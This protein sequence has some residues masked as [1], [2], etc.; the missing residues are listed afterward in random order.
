MR[1]PRAAVP[2]MRRGGAAWGLLLAPGPLLLLA[3][4]VFMLLALWP[5]GDS[6][7]A[8]AQT[9]PALASVATEDVDDV[10]ASVVAGLTNPDSDSATVYMRHRETGGVWPTA[11][12]ATTTGTE[13][14]FALTGLTSLTA[15]QV[16]VSLDAAFAAKQS[17][18]FTTRGPLRHRVFAIDYLTQDVWE[19]G[20][21]S[22]VDG[23]DRNIGRVPADVDLILSLTEHSDHFLYGMDV[24]GSTN[25]LWR[26]NDPDDPASWAEVCEMSSTVPD[27]QAML[28]GGGVLYGVTNNAVYSVNTT[29][30]SF[31][32]IGQLP[33]GLSVARGATMHNGAAYVADHHGEELYRIPDITSPGTQTLNY[34]LPSG[35]APRGLTSSQGQ[36]LLMAESSRTIYR[37]NNPETASPTLTSLGTLDTSA[38]HLNSLGAYATEGPSLS[39]DP[40]LAALVNTTHELAVQAGPS[41]QTATIREV[42]GSTGDLTLS[43]SEAGLSCATQTDSLTLTPPGSIWVMFCSAG[44]NT[45]RIE[46]GGNADTGT[47]YGMTI[48]LGGFGAVADVTGAAASSTSI[49]VM[50]TATAGATSYTVQWRDPS[51]TFSTTRQATATGASA[52]ISSLSAASSYYIRVKAVATGVDGAWSTPIIV[53]T[54][55]FLYVVESDGVDELRTLNPITGS[56][57]LVTAINGESNPHGLGSIAGVLYLIGSVTDQLLR[58][59]VTTGNTTAIGSSFTSSESNPHGLAACDDGLLY[60]VGWA[61][62]RLFSIDPANGTLT[63]IGTSTGFGVGETIPSG[64]ACIGNQLYMAGWSNGTLYELDKTDGTASAVDSSVIAFGVS[65]G[66][67]NGLANIGGV[68]YMNGHTTD[69]LYR[70]S[71]T[72]GIATL[73]SSIGTDSHYGLEMLTAAPGGVSNVAVSGTSMSGVSVT[74]NAGANA[75]S[76]KIRWRKDSESFNDTRSTTSTTTSTAITGLE[77]STVYYVDVATQRTGFS[78]ATAVEAFGSTLSGSVGQVQNVSASATGWDSLS[79]TWDAVVGATTYQVQ[80]RELPQAFSSARQQ[81]A[82]GTSTTISGLEGNTEYFIRVWAVGTTEGATSSP[83]TAT[84]DTR[85]PDQATNVSATSTTANSVTVTWNAASRAASYKV[86]WSTVSGVYSALSQVVTSATSATISSLLSG[87]TYYVQVIATNAG[88]DATPS[89]TSSATTLPGQA[90]G[91]ALSGET[92]ASINA[93]WSPVTGASSYKVQWSLTSGSFSASNQQTSL[94]PSSTISGLTSG[95]LY[96]VR[97]IAVGSAGDGTPSA[98]SSA[99]T[100]GTTAPPPGSHSFDITGFNQNSA[101]W[102]GA[103]L[104]DSAYIENGATA[105]LREVRHTGGSNI[106]I[107]LSSASDDNP[108]D[109]GPQFTDAVELY[110][111]SFEFEAGD[112][113]LLVPGPRYSGNAFTGTI[114]PYHWTVP[115]NVDWLTF[116][117]SIPVGA[118]VTLT[119]HDG[120]T[121]SP[122]NAPPAQVSNLTLSTGANSILASWDATTGATSYRVEWGTSSGSYLAANRQ[123]IVGATS[124]TISGL[125][126]STTYYVRVRASN[127]FGDGPYS[128]EAFVNTEYRVSGLILTD[129][130]SDRLTASWNSLIGVDGYR[131]QWTT[132]PGTYGGGLQTDTVSN[133]AVITGLTSGTVYYVRVIAR[134]AGANYG[135]YST[136]TSARTL[137]SP[138]G[139]VTNVAAT[140]QTYNTISLSWDAVSGATGYKIQWRTSSGQFSASAQIT[141]LTNSG[142]ITGLA[143]GTTYY[144]QVISTKTGAGDGTPSAAI[145]ATTALQSPAKVTGVTLSTTT[146]T[147]IVVSWD[148]TTHATGYTVQWDTTNSFATPVA[149]HAGQD[150]T[151][152]TYT[153]GGL[154]A[155][156]TYYVRVIATRVNAADALP[157][158]VKALTTLL[159]PPPQ[160]TGVTATA[161]NHFSI[162]VAW[163]AS[164]GADE[165]RVEWKSGSQS[166]TSGRSIES[167]SSPASITGLA[168][169]IEYSIRV[170]ALRIRGEDATPSAEVTATTFHRPPS[171][172]AAVSLATTKSTEITVRWSPSDTADD[173]RVQWRDDRGTFGDTDQIITS[174]TSLVIRN[175]T[176][177][178]SYYVRIIPIRT[179]ALPGTPSVPV[180]IR[181]LRTAPD[182]PTNLVLTVISP[183]SIYASWVGVSGATHYKLQWRTSGGAYGQA[184]YRDV[185]GNEFTITGL[186]ASTTYYVRVITHVAGAEDSAGVENSI[187]TSPAGTPDR[188]TGLRV[189][190]S[191]SNTITV[192]WDVAANA[193]TYR[194]QWTTTSGS[195]GSGNQATTSNRVYTVASLAANTTYYLR[196]TPISSGGL[197]GTPSGEVMGFTEATPPAQVTGLALSATD[198]SIT[199]SWTAAAN[200]TG[201]KVQWNTAN[202]FTSGYEE[203]SIQGGS[204]TDYTITGL[205]G[206][207]TYYVRVVSVRT[208]VADGPPSSVGSIPTAIVSTVTVAPSHTTAV[209]TVNMT[210]TEGQRRVYRRY[211]TP[212][213]TGIFGGIISTTTSNGVG[214]FSLS[215]LNSNT[216]YQVEVSTDPAFPAAKTVSTQ[217]TTT[218]TLTVLTGMNADGATNSSVSVTGSLSNPDRQS[219]AVYT[220]YQ[221]PAGSGS[222][223]SW[224]TFTTSG[225]SFSF[226]LSGLA[227]GNTYR[228][229][230]TLTSGFSDPAGIRSDDFTTTAPTVASVTVT[231]ITLNSGTANIGINN[232]DGV[233]ASFYLRY[234]R[235]SGSWSPTVTLSTGAASTTYGLTGLT[236]SSGYRVQVADAPSFSPSAQR[237]FITQANQPPSFP[238][239]TATRH[240]REAQAPGALVG[241]PVAATDQDPGDSISYSLSGSGAA[242]FSI[243]ANTG[244][245]ATAAVLDHETQEIYQVTVTATDSYSGTDTIAVTIRATNVV[246]PP[247]VTPYLG[248]NGKLNQDFRF[249]LGPNVAARLTEDRTGAGDLTFASS[250]AALRCNSQRNSIY[251]AAGGSFWVRYCALGTVNLRSQDATDSANFQ[252]YTITVT[253]PVEALPLKDDDNTFVNK[254]CWRIPGCP[255]ILPFLAAIMGVGGVM[256]TGVTHPAAI[257]GTGGVLFGL[258]MIL[259]IPNGFAFLILGGVGVATL[260]LWRTVGE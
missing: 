42:Q 126:A 10:T 166:Y 120:V 215:A 183:S 249:T 39:P 60:M 81:S 13:A 238:G 118:T 176:P 106:R 241:D 111:S 64:L 184:N 167:E 170:V 220:R 58:L 198:S 73:V 113:S 76:Y 62:A 142:T 79:V 172:V 205:D 68:L 224:P 59:D 192:Q 206:G 70:V 235:G 12:T 201:Y 43:T 47:D 161:V 53:S 100:T 233:A 259:V 222:W 138:P 160:V 146:S 147:E 217:F 257:V 232:S 77:G 98:E 71:R 99:S 163:S 199:A 252:V 57:T 251:V 51:Q 243:N 108:K 155:N 114:E 213:G 131:V 38:S 248:S 226:T 17:T 253:E 181:T 25:D 256:R 258:F 26:T 40:A 149:E 50:W 208:G 219:V 84:T 19:V 191:G 107:E 109:A 11:Q 128:A 52:A 35:T 119:V 212:P 124:A 207:L 7:E 29:D 195:Y 97:V 18:S 244:Q 254:M 122:A 16:E 105:Y 61:S 41:I 158:D 239:A 125:T 175:L 151:I 236:P 95:T 200:A 203:H 65:E 94:T 44:T 127:S 211:R 157:S 237:Y 227:R 188:V 4:T 229:Q 255:A 247:I 246:E 180:T 179:N 173:Y 225:T 83:V 178:T 162:N 46:D 6:T 1:R 34:S 204:V 154:T 28:S 216:T 54:S 92:D 15:Y 45:L 80:W 104:I 242:A 22:D 75:T 150:G 135:S 228:V 130:S 33:T 48:G 74:W 197:E 101:A 88:G 36:L 234:Q 140:A 168:E 182:P 49:A 21:L 144:I 136:E 85:P 174:D 186:S 121:S 20:D 214:T 66:S 260:I 218:P 102:E 134:R 5:L 31:T 123:T 87:T 187:A 30:C 133:R 137:A 78:D 115:A 82:S 169:N 231:N 132:T 90:T 3:A 194:V 129:L 189:T 116:A 196:V 156:T 37:V 56:E 91:L 250:E 89:S 148:I 245:I 152:N 103:L 193:A 117:S 110:A 210:H 72:T 230:V 67:P 9:S 209:V 177:D 96:Y 14:T 240:V 139:P 27:I 202:V 32:N 153:I 143:E 171:R 86:Q 8:Q 69:S 221:T 93:S 63:A 141:T 190:G 2:L 145:T 159:P 164:A 223:V 23:S 55:D 112:Q 165:Y 185:V 24:Q